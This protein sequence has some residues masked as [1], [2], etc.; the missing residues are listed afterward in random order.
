MGRVEVLE[1]DPPQIAQPLC[2]ADAGECPNSCRPGA[3]RCNADLLEQCAGSGSSWGLVQQCD[4]PGLCDSVEG[5]CRPKAC[6]PLQY[7]CAETGDLVVCNTE[8]TGFMLAQR[9]EPGALCNATQG[10]ETCGA[11]ICALGDRRCNGAQLEE[12]RSDRMGFAPTGMV[13]GSAALCRE[14]VPGQARCEPPTC[15]AGV[16]VCEARELR[17]CNENS[18][19]WTVMDRCVTAP[20]CRA[21]LQLC[22]TPTCAIGQQRCTGGV[23]ERCKV[24]QTDYA[25]VADCG[26]PA[27][28]DI[29]VMTCLT[30]PAPP[31]VTPPVTL[32]P[33]TLPPVTL[34]PVTPPPTV[35][36]PP[37]DVLSGAAYT[38]ADAPEVAALGLN[39]NNLSVPREWTQVDNTPWRNAAGTTLGPR[40]VISRDSARFSSR[41]DIPGV[42]F[43]A[44]K[45]APISA[46]TRLAEF[47]LSSQCTRDTSDTYTDALYT[48]PRQSWINCG[49]T[50]ARTVVIAAAPRQSPN[51]V[52]IVIVTTVAERDVTARQNAWDSFEVTTQ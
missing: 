9:C 46:A 25:P 47:D 50:G 6:E 51:F 30:T 45:V 15:T 22:M 49:T 33:V 11:V 27:L 8:L 36:A 26:D 39:L 5:V 37:A 17:L 42:L 19:G 43:A 3:F 2:G 34:P 38:F 13:C 52:T 1:D 21:E 23:L 20:L 16:Y 24:D 31:P 14:D 40:L 10:Q 48:G 4:T 41:F 29:R 28:C 7:D 12:C 35:P 44:T 18:S 32:P